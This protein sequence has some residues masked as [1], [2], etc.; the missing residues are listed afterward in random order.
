MKEKVKKHCVPL[1]EFNST[2]TRS[3][4]VTTAFKSAKLHTVFVTL[5]R[6]LSFRVRAT[7]SPGD[8]SGCH[9]TWVSGAMPPKWVEP[10]DTAPYGCLSGYA[11]VPHTSGCGLAPCLRP[12]GVGQLLY[13]MPQ[14]SM[15]TY[16]LIHR[17][18]HTP[19]LR[20]SH[21]NVTDFPSF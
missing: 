17:R 16:A 20:R 19:P 21:H 9:T 4:Q 10:R 5:G 11:P 8:I 13:L 3:K 18:T 7:L 1:P 2:N 15:K 12:Q 6:W 14:V